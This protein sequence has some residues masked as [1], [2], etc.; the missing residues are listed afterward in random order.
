ML[1]IFLAV[2][3]FADWP[4]FAAFTWRG[5]FHPYRDRDTDDPQT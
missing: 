5:M 1:L 4:G 2:C 3:L